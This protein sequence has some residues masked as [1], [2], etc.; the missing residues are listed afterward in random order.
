VAWLSP[1]AVET[2]AGAS[3]KSHVELVDSE[4]LVQGQPRSLFAGMTGKAEI[5][6]GNRSL[7]EYVFEP[8]RQLKENFS[9]VPT[10]ISKR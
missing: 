4:I 9:D 8:L 5:V 7:I 6:I 10:Q 1:A 2:N 3:F